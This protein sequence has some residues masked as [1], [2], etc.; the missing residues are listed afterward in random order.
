MARK[1]KSRLV[2][3]I[4]FLFSWVFS[5][6]SFASTGIQVGD[7]APEFSLIDQNNKQRALLD[8]RGSW[9]IIY[10]Y[11]KDD[12]PGCTKEACSFR[13]DI[14]Q[15]NQLNAKLIGISMDSQSSHK[16]FAEKFHLPFPLLADIDGQVSQ[17]YGA[18][19]S[20]VLF[21][22]SRRHSFIVNPQGEI[23]KIYR[24]VDPDNHSTEVISD[25]TTLINAYHPRSD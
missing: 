18:L 10:F 5:A 6:A 19:M 16:N 13:D 25:L 15:I 20:L 9:L 7:P 23:A 4:S 22:F 1:H 2:N 24:E 11:P 12:T 8:Y 21:K 17:Q 3:A 14:H